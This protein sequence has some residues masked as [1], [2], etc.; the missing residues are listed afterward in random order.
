MAIAYF[1]G[2]GREG[3]AGKTTS[4]QSPKDRVNLSDRSKDCKRGG[5]Q[6]LSL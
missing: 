3:F 5:A 1:L 2:V 4:E 6:L